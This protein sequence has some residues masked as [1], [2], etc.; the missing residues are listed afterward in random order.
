MHRCDSYHVFDTEFNATAIDEHALAQVLPQLQFP[1]DLTHL[2]VVH[3]SGWE[4]Q[5][6]AA[7]CRVLAIK[8][9]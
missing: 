6:F 4:A 2:D 1:A 8:A 9:L 3:G 7:I 5:G